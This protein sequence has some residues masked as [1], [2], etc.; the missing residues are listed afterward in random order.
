ME[1]LYLQATELYKNGEYKKAFSIFST[2]SKQNH[3]KSSNQLAILY[4]F[5]KGTRKNYKKTIY[6]AKIGADAN[7]CESQYILGIIYQMGFGVKK[8]INSAIEYLTLSAKQN[9][10][11]A[12]KALANVYCYD[13]EDYEKSIFWQEK[14]AQ[15]NFLPC[16]YGLA[17]MYKYGNGVEQNEE[18]SIELCEKILRDNN[19]SPSLVFDF[20]EL[21]K[22]AMLCLADF[23]TKQ[24]NV[25]DK[26]DKG[27]EYYY[28]LAKNEKYK[29]HQ[30]R[31]KHRLDNLYYDEMRSKT[32]NSDMIFYWH[33]KA[34]NQNW[35]YLF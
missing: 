21:K 35:N 15:Q 33:N 7:F 16:L 3:T 5:G 34:F 6:Y 9:N 8:D 29:K 4:F 1:K 26:L 24:K 19:S 13:L 27:L 10:L 31:A 20:E 25:K 2:L 18:K 32:K 30:K 14:G 23:Y 17:L 11:D 22:S 12:I 28:L